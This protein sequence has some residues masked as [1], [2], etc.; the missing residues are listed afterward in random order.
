MRL[1]AITRVLNEADII[2]S[3]VR[4]TARFTVHHILMDN[5]S[6]DGTVEILSSLADEGLPLSL[7][8]SRAVTFNE[9]D[10]LTQLY[11]FA[12]SHRPNWVLCLDADEFIDDRHVPGELQGRLAAYGA[13]SNGPNCIKIPMVNYIATSHDVA[14]ERIVPLRMRRRREPSDSCKIILRGD[15]PADRL[16][17][18]H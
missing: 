10:S 7:Y 15:L 16:V 8:Q 11:Q 6:S 13:Q 17:I 9:S 18:Q 12:V 2:E 14:D 3:F 5:G 1:V 4:H